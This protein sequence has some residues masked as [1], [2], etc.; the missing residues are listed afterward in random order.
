MLSLFPIETRNLS[1]HIKKFTITN[2]KRY[3]NLLSKILNS[4]PLLTPK[5]KILPVLSLS[6]HKWKLS[7]YDKPFI[8]HVYNVVVSL[9]KFFYKIIQIVCALWLA[10]NHFT[11]AY[12]NTVFVP[13]SLAGNHSASRCGFLRLSHV[14]LTSHVFTSGYVN[15]ETI[16]HFFT[17]TF[18]PI[19]HLYRMI[20]KYKQ[21]KI[22]LR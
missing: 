14:L 15:T 8:F 10:I 2:K 4:L 13:L 19:F 7:S 22:I 20:Y 6:L 5:F 17:L 3:W 11:W 16:L 21:V 1:L 12:V 9:F 18:F